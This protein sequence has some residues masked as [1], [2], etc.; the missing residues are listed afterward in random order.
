MMVV[1]SLI[2]IHRMNNATSFNKRKTS[3]MSSITI[4][5]N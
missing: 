5:V 4:Q 2:I 3:V 1:S